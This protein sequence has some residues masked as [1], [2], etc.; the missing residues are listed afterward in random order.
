[1]LIRVD[2]IYIYL[3][4]T[5]LSVDFQRIKNIYTNL[6]LTTLSVS[7]YDFP[8]VCDACHAHADARFATVVVNGGAEMA[9]FVGSRVGV[10]V[11]R[12]A[13]VGGRRGHGLA[14][15]G[16]IEFLG[17]CES[18]QYVASVAIGDLLGIVGDG[19]IDHG[20]VFAIQSRCGERI[21]IA[22]LEIGVESEI[23]Q[24]VEV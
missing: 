23:L 18:R 16:R 22:R 17:F 4:N 15:V 9:V 8:V 19:F 20:D 11:E 1:M 7:D 6:Q 24:S 21:G 5:T 3:H 14:V 10:P 12:A 13:I 2:K